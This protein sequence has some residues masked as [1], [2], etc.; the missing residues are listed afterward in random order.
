MVSI[1]GFDVL[2]FSGCIN[3][4]ILDVLIFSGQINNNI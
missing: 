4:S 2:Y 3:G 1:L